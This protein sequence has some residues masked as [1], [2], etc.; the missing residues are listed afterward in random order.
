[1]QEP[2]ASAAKPKAPVDQGRKGVWVNEEFLPPVASWQAAPPE[3]AG[4]VPS[5]A[6]PKAR[7]F[8]STVL[9]VGM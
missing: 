3:D 7:W 1:M 5:A 9:G 6:E 2:G 8:A 4:D